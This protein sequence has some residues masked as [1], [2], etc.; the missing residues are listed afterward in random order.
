MKNPCYN[1]KTHT[2]CPRRKAGCASS[3]EDWQE[4]V[5]IRD[6]VYKSRRFEFLSRH[7]ETPFID[8]KIKQDLSNRKNP[9][10]HGGD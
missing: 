3:C 9:R 4:Y 1:E 7:Q 2:D 10:K 5:K 8:R 6:E